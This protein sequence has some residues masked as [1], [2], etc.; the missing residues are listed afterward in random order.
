MTSFEKETVVVQETPP[1]TKPESRFKAKP[2]LW[3]EAMRFADMLTY[4][5][6]HQSRT[7]SR[8]LNDYIR[9]VGIKFD[10]KGNMHKKIGDAPILW[11]CHIDTVHQKKGFQKIEYWINKD[12]DTFLGVQNGEKSSC[13]GAD[14]TAGV[15]MMLE[16]IKRGV[17]GHY[18]FHRGEECGG[19]G[20]RWLAKTTPDVLKDIKYAIAFDRR[21]T[22]SV[23]TYQGGTRCCSDE[24]AD[25]LIEQLG[26]KHTKDK[27]G[28]FT[29][30]A[31]YVDLVAECTNISAGYYNAHC[32]SENVNIDYLFKLRDAI[33]K[34]DVS[35]LVEKR[36]PGENTRE[37]YTYTSHYSD[38]DDWS[39]WDGYGSNKTRPEG[40]L[41]YSEMTQKCPDGWTG[42]YQYDSQVGYWMPI[43]WAKK[44]KKDL[45]VT[46]TWYGG[47]YYSQYKS[48]FREAVNM[49]RNNPAIV[50]DLLETL[51]YGPDEL[52]QHIQKTNVNY[53]PF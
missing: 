34:M 48:T 20:S 6:P 22:G 3:E 25:S 42:K 21:D 24:F 43:G 47:Q 5:R 4:C 32:P 44:D 46:K 50:A 19:I 11:S 28:A 8:F 13:L 51:G 49:V 12:G 27:G 53:L 17:E 31:S 1:E 39:M 38:Y 33:C 35:K 45:G 16:M 36:K 7:E 26:M 15:W 30:T 41:D 37:V 14:D 10:K 52:K 9:P 29:D 2:A 40:A 23:I 18:I